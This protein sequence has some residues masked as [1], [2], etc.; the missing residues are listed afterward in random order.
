MLDI[1]PRVQL[2]VRYTYDSLVIYGKCHFH[3]QQIRANGVAVSVKV[4]SRI[5]M[6][7]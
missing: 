3:N 7:I 4:R 2:H 1:L 5:I 6:K